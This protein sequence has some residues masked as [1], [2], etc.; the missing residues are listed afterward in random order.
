MSPSPLLI[1]LDP[2]QLKSVPSDAQLLVPSPQ[3]LWLQLP[4]VPL[5]CDRGR[6]DLFLVQ[7]ALYSSYSPPL[8]LGTLLA[9]CLHFDFSLFLPK[10]FQTGLFAISLL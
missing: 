7:L 5:A 10:C 3:N 6:S 9:L 2:G 8:R 1:Y 4:W